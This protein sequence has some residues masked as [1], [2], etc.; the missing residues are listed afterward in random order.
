M[1]NRCRS[2]TLGRL[3]PP[4]AAAKVTFVHRS[5]RMSAA[6]NLTGGVIRVSG[7]G[8]IKQ[9]LRNVVDVGEFSELDLL[10]NAIA[11][12]GSAGPTAAVKIWTGMQKETDDGWVVI[13]TYTTVNAS[14]VQE[15]KQSLSFLRYIRWEVTLTGTNPVLTFS[16]GGMAKGD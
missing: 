9:D 7:A 1:T 10:L 16:V 2:V 15:L 4:N 12:E 3:P 14:N 11:L 6:I 5:D 8:T 13:I